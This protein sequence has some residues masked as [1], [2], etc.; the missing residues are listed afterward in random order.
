MEQV[1]SDLIGRPKMNDDDARSDD[2]TLKID[3]ADN[4]EEN[5][6]Q[7]DEIAPGDMVALR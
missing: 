2:D 4:V 3:V 6:S 1:E 7:H 5:S